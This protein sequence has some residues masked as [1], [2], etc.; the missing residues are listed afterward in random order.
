MPS[1]D[2]IVAI[3]TPPGRGGIG[4][5]R[6]SGQDLR[7]FAKSVTGTALKPRI[8]TYTDF[9]S[10]DGSVIDVGIAIFFPSPA[11]YTGEDVL[12]LHGHGSPVVMQMLLR[13]CAELGARLAEPGEFTRRAYLNDKLDLAQAESVADI[14]EAASDSAALCALRSLK[15]EFSHAVSELAEDLL[16]LRIW[17]EATLDFP[18]EEIDPSNSREIH[19]RLLALL[20]SVSSTLEKSKQGSILRSGLNVV[21][22]GRPN[23]GKSSLLNRL[24]G[25]EVAIVTAV[26]GTTRDALRQSISVNGIPIHVIDTAGLRVPT[27]EVEAIGIQRSWDSMDKAD[28][29]LFVVEAGKD[30]RD[31]DE[32]IISKLPAKLKRITVFNKS[33]LVNTEESIIEGPFGRS[34]LVSAKTGAGMEDLRQAL[35]QAAGWQSCGEDVFMGRARHVVALQSTKDALAGAL[36]LM[37][38]PELL[39]EELRAAHRFMGSIIGEVSPDDLLGEIFSRFCIGK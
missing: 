5:V 30:V 35:Q 24:A 2:T 31:A 15:G 36:D 33:D 9:L 29:V 13:R 3:A 28:V 14:I 19:A 25:E 11:S 10:A 20:N 32:E 4:I 1:D 38:R 22:A 37:E 26:P 39:A 12:E 16:A 21:L 17:V 7:A 18:E 8:A 23:V 6:V 27:D 34:V